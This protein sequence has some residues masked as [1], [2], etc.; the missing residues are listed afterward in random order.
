M[1]IFKRSMKKRIKKIKTDKKIKEVLETLYEYKNNTEQM[2]I[3]QEKECKNSLERLY[4]T[5]NNPQQKIL[6][7][8]TIIL[9]ESLNNISYLEN[10]FNKHSKQFIKVK[11][12]LEDQSVVDDHKKLYAVSSA[13][14]E[15]CNE[16]QWKNRN[17]KKYFNDSIDFVTDFDKLYF[18][19]IKFCK[20]YKSELLEKIKQKLVNYGFYYKNIDDMEKDFIVTSKSMRKLQKNMEKIGKYFLVNDHKEV[21]F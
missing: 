6:D 18:Y 12:I 15:L 7:I 17:F 9:N 13:F 2:F 8:A 16:E 4:I 20:E 1:K 14:K 10:I 21:I 11:K 19:Q 5:S 3:L